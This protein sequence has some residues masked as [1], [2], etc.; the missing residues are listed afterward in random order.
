M[1]TA[2]TTADP[3]R[4][5][6]TPLGQLYFRGILLFCAVVLVAILLFQAYGPNQGQSYDDQRGTA[7]LAKLQALRAEEQKT[8]SNYSWA[9]KEKGVARIPIDRAMELVAAD[10]KNATASASS[11]KV[12]NPYPAGLP[13]QAPAATQPATSGSAAPA[14]AAAPAKAP[15]PEATK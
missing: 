4:A 13:A 8:L 15:A 1:T 3:A 11:V 9:N 10:L 14:A 7:R 2:N 5:N 6:N 12:E